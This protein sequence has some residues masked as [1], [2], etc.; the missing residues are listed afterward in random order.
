MII[1]GKIMKISRTSIDDVNVVVKIIIE[2]NDYQATVNEILKDYRKK[3]NMPGFRK[4]MVPAGLIKK[5]YGKS[6]LADEVNKIL[7]RELTKYITDE[8]LNILGEPLPS[9]EE[10]SIIDFNSDAD[11]EFSFDMGLSPEISL[12]FEK[13]GKIPYYEIIV[14]NKLIDNQIDGYSKRFGENVNA[15]VVGEKEITIGDFAQLNADGLVVEGGIASKNVQVAVQLIKDEAVQNLF[16]GAKIGDVIKFNPRIALANDHEVAHLLKIKNE[17]IE[18]SDCDF[19]FT[20]NTINTFVPADIDD[21]LIRKIYGDDTEVKSVDDLREKIQTELK[22]NL[23]YSSNYRFLV[24]AKEILSHSVGMKLPEQFLKRWLVETNNKVPIEQIEN[25]FESFRK[26][27]EWTLIKNILVKE[28]EIMVVESDITEMA[29]E[30]ALLQFKQHGMSFVPDEYLENY[31]NSIL[32]NK[33]QK[34]KLAEKK[35]ED[36]VLELI[37]EKSGLDF[38]QVT[39]K[40]FD[41]LFE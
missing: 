18:D 38:K 7:N 30:M 17:A 6:A 16:I 41:S 37:K 5:M 21:V 19:N 9:I 31:T 15:E 11:F 22:A 23:L 8:N 32:Q 20:I 4:G 2:K 13:I 33:E 34:Q 10:K 35:I 29:R 12:D 26:D 40:E 36:K 24:D 14:D 39:Q 27:L 28:N 1:K 25:E 3:A